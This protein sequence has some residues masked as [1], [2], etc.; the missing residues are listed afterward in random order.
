VRAADAHRVS[1]LYYVEWNT[2][3]SEALHRVMQRSGGLPVDGIQRVATPWPDWEIST[4][5]D[6]RASWPAV[7]NAVRCHHTQINTYRSL[8]HLSAE[9]HDAIWGT[10][11]FYRA[12]SLVNSGRATETDLFEGLR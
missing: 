8:E 11:E 6:T 2:R 3:K 12:Y 1:K 9:D 4:V 7:W 10:Q 5:I